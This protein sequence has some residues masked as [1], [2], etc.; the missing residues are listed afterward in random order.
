MKAQISGADARAANSSK[1]NW[2]PQSTWKAE[3]DKRLQRAATEAAA[4]LEKSRATWQAETKNRL[5]AAED[6]ARKQIEQTRA[7]TAAI[8]TKRPSFAAAPRALD[9]AVHYSRQEND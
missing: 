4:A 2:R 8:R 9:H 7:E 5:A 3:L 6:R 1:T